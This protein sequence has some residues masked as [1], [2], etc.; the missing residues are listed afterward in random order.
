MRAVLRLIR[1]RRGVRPRALALGLL[2]AAA[3]SAQAGA[4]AQVPT[5]FEGDSLPDPP[6]QNVAWEPPRAPLPEKLIA[7]TAKLF[8]QGLADPRGCEYHEVEVASG[9]AAGGARRIKT[10]AWVL[11]AAPQPGSRRFAVGWNGLVYPLLSVGEKA[12][13]R[14]DVLALVSED[15]KRRAPGRGAYPIISPY[16]CCPA[17]P[18]FN[19]LSHEWRMLIKAAMLLRLGEGELARKVWDDLNG[20]T[21]AETND[22]AKDKDPYLLLAYEWTWALFDRALSAH[23]LGDDRLSLLSARALVRI[24]DMVESEAASRRLA[25][26]DNAGAAPGERLRYLPF[27]QPLPALLADQERRAREGGRGVPSLRDRLTNGRV[28]VAS[29]SVDE[30]IRNLDEARGTLLG[31]AFPQ[32]KQFDAVIFGGDAVVNALIEKGDEAVE[33][34][35]RVLEDDTRLVRTV[36]FR[37]DNRYERHMIGVQEAAYA[38]LAVILKSSPFG[39]VTPDEELRAPGMER[40]RALAARVRLYLKQY[41]GLPPEERWYRA[42]ADDG[43]TLEQWRLAA[44]WIAT[45]YRTPTSNGWVQSFVPFRRRGEKV[46]PRG[47]ALRQKAGPSVSQLLVR[48]MDDS[49]ARLSDARLTDEDWVLRLYGL[50]DFAVALSAWDG[51]GGLGELR[52]VTVQMERLFA[53][54][55][56]RATYS[57]KSWLV[58][59]IVGI[60]EERLALGDPRAAADYA[61]WLRTVR[62]EDTDYRETSLFAPASRYADS[63][64]IAEAVTWMFDDPSSPWAPVVGKLRYGPDDTL[65][66]LKT[67]LLRFSA[68]RARVLEGLADRTV[69]GTL[70]PRAADPAGTYDPKVEYELKVENLLAAAVAGE[71]QQPDAV[72]RFTIGPRSLAPSLSAPVSFRACDVYAWKLRG[73]EGAPWIEL[74]WSEEARD[75]AVASSTKFLRE[76]NGPFVYSE[77]RAYRQP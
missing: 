55:K 23:V 6:Q 33:P 4:A 16:N 48:R 51:E 42:L 14:Q 40:R 37:S 32:F 58:S 34:L 73:F 75:S 9:T 20:D 26:P 44:A 21:S 31:L 45:P 68:F 24:R 15:E 60:Y 54:E 17:T 29:V 53:S 1:V 3:T 59:D 36:R 38:A 35:I 67:G 39:G 43:A 72:V 52:R 2:L 11:P 46:V 10:H 49:F 12:D 13:L 8:E 25:P 70:K 71:T 5:K 62:P 41:A 77:E 64:E 69:V 74:Y 7:A 22:D 65:Y 63:P 30:L 50:R 27:L 19:S 61:G 47:E 56:A 57:K 76:H 18:N 66:L 28:Q